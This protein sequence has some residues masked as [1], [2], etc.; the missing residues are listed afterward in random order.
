MK[1]SLS[2]QIFDHNHQTEIHLELYILIN[3]GKDIDTSEEVLKSGRG[4]DGV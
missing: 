3:F 1:L 4:S 2:S